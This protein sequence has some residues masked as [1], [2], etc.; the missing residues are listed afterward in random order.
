MFDAP[1][2]FGQKLFNSTYCLF[3]RADRHSGSNH[4]HMFS[5]FI[6]LARDVGGDFIDTIFARRVIILPFS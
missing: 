5:R 6:L 2:S 3:H 1:Y 4:G